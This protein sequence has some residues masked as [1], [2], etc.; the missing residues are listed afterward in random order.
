MAVPKLHDLMWVRGL[1][2]GGLRD[3]RE[4]STDEIRYLCGSVAELPKRVTV[5]GDD[6][7]PEKA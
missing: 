6:D 5:V 3:R 7:T 4:L 2:A 1:A